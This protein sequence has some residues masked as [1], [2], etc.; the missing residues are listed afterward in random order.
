[1]I[2]KKLFFMIDLSKNYENV[3]KRYKWR[4]KRNFKIKSIINT[5]YTSL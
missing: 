4:H 3:P 1:M 5:Y 2:L